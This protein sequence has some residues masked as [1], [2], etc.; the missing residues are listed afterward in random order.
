[1]RRGAG[2]G[3]GNLFI[4]TNIQHGRRE[5]LGGTFVGGPSGL[6][7]EDI[8][9]TYP[10][11]ATC[12]CRRHGWISAHRGTRRSRF[13]NVPDARPA[14]REDGGGEGRG[15]DDMSLCWPPSLPVSSSH[16]LGGTSWNHLQTSHLY[17]PLCFWNVGGQEPCAHLPF[18]L[19]TM[20]Q[21]L[22][23]PVVLW[24]FCYDVPRAGHGKCVFGGD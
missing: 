1:M 22:R 16:A 4:C 17:L 3:R 23:Q 15:E 10:A 18:L 14:A 7:C 20:Q 9:S 12:R 21:I 8:S 24:H 19:T 6:R 13:Q 11:S 2:E 5:G